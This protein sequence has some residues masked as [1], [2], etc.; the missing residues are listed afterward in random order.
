MSHPSPTSQA[1]DL[2]SAIE[3]TLSG[4]IESPDYHATH[5]ACSLVLALASSIMESA[6]EDVRE[7]LAHCPASPEQ[8]LAAID[9]RSLSTTAK[10]LSRQVSQFAENKY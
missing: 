3:R 5:Q 9:L 4:V 8:A 6:L 7:V 1:A 2:V 10:M